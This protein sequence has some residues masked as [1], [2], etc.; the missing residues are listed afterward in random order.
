MPVNVD[1]ASSSNYFIL[2]P[3]TLILIIIIFFFFIVVSCFMDS[4]LLGPDQESRRDCDFRPGLSEPW[5]K[6]IPPS[7]F[8]NKVSLNSYAHLFT[9][10][11]WLPFHYSGRAEELKQRFLGLQ[12]IAHLLSGP[13]EIKFDDPC[14]RL[15]N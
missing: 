14:F 11:L 10:C 9:Y 7:D 15:F 3:M 1:S 12:S 8:V 2:D 13:L 5:S 4:D 6:K